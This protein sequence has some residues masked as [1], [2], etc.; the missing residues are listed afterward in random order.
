MLVMAGPGPHIVQTGP[1]HEPFD[2]DGEAATSCKLVAGPVR[3]LNVIADRS[4]QIDH[5][6]AALDDA[7]RPTE[8]RPARRH[9]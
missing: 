4:L 8:L 1:A 6:V 3:D 2:F 5:R 9:G 7:S